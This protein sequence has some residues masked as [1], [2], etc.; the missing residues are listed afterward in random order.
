MNALEELLQSLAR[1]NDYR[2]KAAMAAEFT[3]ISQS[4]TDREAFRKTINVI[5]ILRWFDSFLLGRM[6]GISEKE[7]AKRIESLKGFSFVEKFSSL[8][9]ERFNV[10]ELTRLGWRMQ[11]YKVISPCFEKYPSAH[12]LA[13]RTTKPHLVVLKAFTIK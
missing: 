7:A 8:G 5:A 13:L 10:H 1:E 9:L 12:R 2:L 11:M 4:E 6:L 3:V